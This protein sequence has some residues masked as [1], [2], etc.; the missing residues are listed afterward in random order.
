MNGY[1]EVVNFIPLMR[2]ICFGPWWLLV[3]TDQIR[4]WS[5]LKSQVHFIM[6]DLSDLQASGLA[7]SIGHSFKLHHEHFQNAV[8]AGIKYFHCKGV[9]SVS[10]KCIAA[11][12]FWPS[13]EFS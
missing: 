3:R 2:G 4:R 7:K 13:G 1:F 11:E 12:T 9:G 10:V 6:S 5:N 8:E